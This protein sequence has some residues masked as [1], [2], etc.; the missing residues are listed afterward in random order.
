MGWAALLA[1][2]LCYRQDADQV[3]PHGTYRTKIPA[4]LPSYQTNCRLIETEA[5]MTDV[6]GS[7]FA[8]GTGTQFVVKSGEGQK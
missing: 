8:E 4:E 1:V 6:S 7:V 2:S 5:I 3:S